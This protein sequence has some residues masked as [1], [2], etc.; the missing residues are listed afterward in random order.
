MLERPDR[1]ATTRDD[2]QL[3]GGGRVE[4]HQRRGRDVLTRL[5]PHAHCLQLLVRPHPQRGSVGGERLTDRCRQ[6]GG[7]VLGLGTGPGQPGQCRVGPHVLPMDDGPAGSDREQG[8]RE[9][10]RNRRPPDRE[11]EDQSGYRDRGCPQHPAQ[12]TAYGTVGRTPTG[13]DGNH[14]EQLEADVHRMRDRRP[15][16]RDRSRRIWGDGVRGDD[17]GR[18]IVDGPGRRY[19]GAHHGERDHECGQGTPSGRGQPT[20]GKTDDG[21]RAQGECDHQRPHAKPSPP[22][23]RVRGG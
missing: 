20:V 11:T 8:R 22:P 1:L 16:P 6:V 15:D 12:L 2:A 23:A 14:P 21:E 4:G 3:V 13:D 7:Q 10:S 5:R 9:E 19:R 18:R 17:T